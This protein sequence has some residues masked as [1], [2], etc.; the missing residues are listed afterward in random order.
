MKISSRQLI[1][2]A[3]T[4]TAFVESLKIKYEADTDFIVKT[5]DKNGEEV[6]DINKDAVI[7]INKFYGYKKLNS[8][9]QASMDYSGLIDS[10]PSTWREAAGLMGKEIADMS[11]DPIK[12][13]LI[14]LGLEEEDIVNKE[15]RAWL[16]DRYINNKGSEIHPISEALGTLKE[17][18]GLKD[19]ILSRI[20]TD[21]DF[22]SNLEGVGFT[23]D[24]LKN[25][26]SLSVDNMVSI[27]N[28]YKYGEKTTIRTY[29]VEIREGERIG[30]VEEWN[31]WLPQTQETSAKIAG[32]DDV[33]KDPKTTWCTGRTKGSNL[34]YN[35]VSCGNIIQFL[36]YIIRDNPKGARDWLSMGFVGDTN[37]G[38]NS[39]KPVYGE[40]GGVTINRDNKGLSEK[41][42]R[43][44][45]GKNY[46]TIFDMMK[47]KIVELGGKNPATTELE[48]YAKNLSLFKKALWDKSKEERED[49]YKIILQLDPSYEVEKIIG[50]HYIEKDPHDFLEF[51]SKK[52]W[53]NER[54]EDLGNKTLV[55][56]TGRKYAEEAPRFFL[57]SF[58][59]EQWANERREDLGNTTL[60]EYARE[61]SV[62]KAPRFFLDSFS[63]EQWANERRENLGNKTL[64]EYARDEYA[65]KDPRYFL[66]YFSNQ[67]WANKKREDLD[68]KTLVEYARIGY[69]KKEP[70]LFLR[71]F[72]GMQWANKK[73]VDLG[74]KT[75]VE[76]ASYNY[77]EKDSHDFLEES[78]SYGEWVNEKIE[79]LD[80]KTLVQ[81]ARDKFAKK[82][83]S[84]FLS[85]YSNEQWA[86]ER[87]ED[88][89]NKTLVEYASYNYVEKDP[90]QFLDSF[91]HKEWANKKRKDLGNKTLVE[92]AR[93]GHAKK[94]P[95]DFL[96]SFPN[97]QWAN[98][99]REDLGNKTL[100]EYAGCN[101]AEEHPSWFLNSFY[102]EQWANERRENLGN[103]TLVEYAK[104]LKSKE[105]QASLR[106]D[107][108]R[109]I[110]LSNALRIIGLS[111]EASSILNLK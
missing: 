24:K 102:G 42:F 3:V 16:E 89:D 94:E 28:K 14:S 101:Y 6:I 48:N 84:D 66:T 31:I 47:N 59:G 13:A 58:S 110:K 32:Y 68:N 15:I 30:K 51:F 79:D 5:Q 90:G 104:E 62:E 60:V 108:S 109:L 96:H 87:R 11:A 33:T 74:N 10:L 27:L 19:A 25:I 78:F 76:Y 80:N 45:L 95:S 70:R 71:D 99:K 35:Y 57:S 72:S 77:I 37:G 9:N 100:V 4:K 86:N 82:E 49:F 107:R 85:S 97:E 65:K 56:Y 26:L 17:Y 105:V 73:R 20:K 88:L 23:E 61:K 91:S 7:L 18:V 55:E 21:E 46:S 54:R 2:E 53:A 92:Y 103:K 93:D 106:T 44:I 63:G 75:L 81:Y 83:P 40:D 69:A 50:N 8:V 22:K 111:K 29:G 36:F 1:K 64:V 38:L 34:F 41:D 39:I 67:M 12:A 98:K 52:S 43:K